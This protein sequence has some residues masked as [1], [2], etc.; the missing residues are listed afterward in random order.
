MREILGLFRFTSGLRKHVIFVVLASVLISIL[1]MATPFVMKFATDYVMGHIGDHTV[2]FGPVLWMLG[3]LLVIGVFSNILS[4]ISGYIGDILAIKLRRQLS[5]A[6]FDHLLHLPQSYYDKELTGKITNRLNRALYQVVNFVQ[7]FS[8]NLLSMMLTVII[9]VS[10]MAYYNFWLALVVL[11]LIPVY[12]WLTVKTSAKWQKIEKEKNQH[13]DSALGRFTESIS[14]IRLVKSFGM[15]RRELKNF[16]HEFGDSENLTKTQSAFWHKM[17]FWR[18]SFNFLVYV[19]VLG[20]LF[21]DTIDSQMSAGDLVLLIALFQQT[22]I[23]L[24]NISF[25]VDMYQNAAANSKDFIET[26]RLEPES[27]SSK[28]DLVLN[29]KDAKIEFKQVDFQYNQK[30][31]KVLKN[32]SFKINAGEKVALVGGSGGGKTTITNLM[33]RFY[34]PDDGQILIADQDISSLNRESLRKNVATVFQEAPLF[35][36][37]IMENIKYGSPKASKEQV[38]KAAKA[39]NAHNFIMKLSDGYNTEIGE[40]GTKLSG[41]QKQRISIARALLRDA[42]ILILDEATSALDSESEMIV[43]EALERLMKGR[44]TIIIAHRLSTIANVDK[45]ATLDKGR[46]DEFGSPEELAKS[47]GIYARLL[48]IQGKAT[49]AS[50]KQLKKFD[51]SSLR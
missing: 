7:I 49:K 45:I 33:M 48:S 34:E 11:V 32:I 26:M 25:F 46:I 41:G 19:V 44:T 51:I 3:I 17:D 15:Q 40:R 38:E 22:L 27:E 37:T 10:V 21:K 5:A 20:I 24:R 43:Q 2:N 14:Q 50:I 42:P 6:Y 13:L 30:D 47:G 4:T 39:A 36:G 16:D 29:K 31:G 12:L 35:S 28:K 18:I 9:S 23:P 1:G 8:N